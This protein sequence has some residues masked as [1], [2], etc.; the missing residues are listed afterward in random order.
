MHAHMIERI[1]GR[2]RDLAHRAIEGDRRRDKPLVKHLRNLASIA[3]EILGQP[4]RASAAAPAAAPSATTASAP[5][6][7]PPAPIAAP[8]FLYFDGK[9]HRTKA[10][11]EELL[12][13]RQIAF[14]VLDV[15]DDE[16]ERSWVTTTAR[17]NEFPIVVIAGTPV[18][19]LAEL[20]QLDLT[21]DL[22]RKVFG[23]AT[24]SGGSRS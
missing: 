21:G 14:K 8:V 16:A 15:T 9:D 10:K 18:G 5:P 2:M 4:I 12:G 20:T 1:T 19:G 17:T 24:F 11:I 22:A 3:N 6:V 7:A 13:S 23:A